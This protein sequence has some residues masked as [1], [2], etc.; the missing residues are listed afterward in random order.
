MTA[1]G[2]GPHSSQGLPRPLPVLTVAE[3]GSGCEGA[4]AQGAQ[5]RLCV[6]PGSKDRHATASPLRL[7]GKFL[8]PSS[9]RLPPAPRLDNLNPKEGSFPRGAGC[10]GVR[11]LTS[12]S[13]PAEHTGASHTKN[14]CCSSPFLSGSPNGAM[15]ETLSSHLPTAMQVRPPRGPAPAT[16][17][18]V[19]SPLSPCSPSSLHLGPAGGRTAVRP[20]H[21]PSW[22]PA[23]LPKP[24]S[25]CKRLCAQ[26]PTTSPEEA[27]CLG[28]GEPVKV[29]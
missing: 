16:P 17:A 5:P 26:C 20:C 23:T 25:P 7:G 29:R 21:S 8:V 1:T 3:T 15:R 18:P 22:G 6:C 27:R 28:K 10:A 19:L 4:R 12:V 13:G 2:T 11:G 14:R 9:P 24:L